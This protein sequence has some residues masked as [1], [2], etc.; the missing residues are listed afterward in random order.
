MTEARNWSDERK[1]APA[2]KE[3][4]FWKLKK[5]RKQILLSRVFTRN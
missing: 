4:H 1:W 2:K 5:A 3:G